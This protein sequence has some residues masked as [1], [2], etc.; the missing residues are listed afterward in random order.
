MKKSV[1]H[2]SP[3]IWGTF[4]SSHDDGMARAEAEID[5][6]FTDNRQQILEEKK[7]CTQ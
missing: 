2:S 7:K 5:R 3:K 1:P 4:R 6:M